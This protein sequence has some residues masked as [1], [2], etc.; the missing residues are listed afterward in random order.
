LSILD[1]F[2]TGHF[3]IGGNRGLNDRTYGQDPPI[4]LPVWH[5]TAFAWLK[6]APFVKET[7]ENTDHIRRKSLHKREEVHHHYWEKAY[8]RDVTGNIKKDSH[9]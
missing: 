7:Y 2:L 5:V 1:N 4:S 3:C 8:S 9:R 6:G